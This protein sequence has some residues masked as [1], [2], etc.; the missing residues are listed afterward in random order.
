MIPHNQNSCS[1][2]IFFKIKC[3][4]SEINEPYIKTLFEQKITNFNISKID[5]LHTGDHKIPKI[6]INS[7][8]FDILCNFSHSATKNTDEFSQKLSDQENMLKLL[9]NENKDL[10][11]KV[12]FLQAEIT[13]KNNKIQDLVKQIEIRNS[14][15]QLSEK[16]N[17][18]DKPLIIF[19][20][21]K[22][23]KLEKEFS[24]KIVKLNSE[25]SDLLDELQKIKL[26]SLTK[27]EQN[28]DFSSQISTLQNT[29]KTLE[30]QNADLKSQLENLLN[31]NSQ[32]NK[33]NSELHNE[34][35]K[36]KLQNAEFLAENSLKKIS[37]VTTENS[38]INSLGK[39]KSFTE[40]E[41]EN[42]KSQNELLKNGLL[43]A[44]IVMK[45]SNLEITKDVKMYAD[46]IRKKIEFL[47]ENAVCGY[48]A[49]LVNSR[50]LIFQEE[51]K[52]DTLNEILL[53]KNTLKTATL[54]ELRN[55]CTKYCPIYSK[56]LKNNENEEYL[57]RQFLQYEMRKSQ[58]KLDK[59]K[60]NISKFSELQKIAY[61]KI[62]EIDDKIKEKL[63]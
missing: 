58:L 9:Q 22:I 23:Q 40:E 10:L 46:N 61:E 39:S 63:F 27:F 25:K 37:V 15:S 49:L 28:N 33:E 6:I 4:I 44:F 38:E 35:S 52:I 14:I 12:Q 31:Y 62:Q 29:V 8:L 60:E 7:N 20:E 3:K 32:K 55:I 47:G 41:F 2:D 36:L 21:E 42:L 56:I 54:S 57:L 18:K 43:E 50:D 16:I 11:E 5:I 1:A 51:Q 30:N 45:Y 59:S 53:L 13:E 17:K 26:I 24:E 19:L 48:T 34:I